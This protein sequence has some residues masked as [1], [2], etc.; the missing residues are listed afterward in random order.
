MSQRAPSHNYLSGS[1]IDL[2]SAP[3]AP[4][5]ATA[6]QA[7]RA[8]GREPCVG[9][10][11]ESGGDTAPAPGHASLL[12]GTFPEEADQLASNNG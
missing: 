5:K 11:G 12:T 6:V 1:L 2:P 7:R 4:G 9:P 10:L 3:E 8:G